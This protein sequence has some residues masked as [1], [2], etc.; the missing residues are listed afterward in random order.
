MNA[1]ISLCILLF[2]YGAGYDGTQDNK[3][4]FHLSTPKADYG[5]VLDE[6]GITCDV[7]CEKNR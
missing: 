2:G 4:Y 7:V 3:H 1:L 5:F 6:S